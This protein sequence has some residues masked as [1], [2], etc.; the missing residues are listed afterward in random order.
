ML[1][2]SVAVH[3]ADDSRHS[4]RL[5]LAVTLSQRFD[6][7]LNV[8]YATEG[9][10][11]P[12]GTIGRSASMQYMDAGRDDTHARI[13][14]ARQ[15]CERHCA[16]L[17]SWEWHQAH[18]PVDKIVARFA[19]LADLV[20]AEQAPRI[21]LEDGLIQHMS[22]F[23]VI[24]AGC[25]M[26]LVPDGWAAGE[27]G[28]RVLVAWKNEPQ[29]IAAIRGSLDFLSAATEVHVLAAADDRDVDPPG[30]DIV[31]YLAH[32]GVSA[33]VCGIS[34]RGGQD[35]LS[36]AEALNC[37]L[38]VMGAYAHSRWRELVLGGATDH[39]MR[40]ATIPVLMRH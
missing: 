21:H 19:H 32:H 8:V 38:I 7:H 31:R 26:L 29:A 17:R 37:D 36:T 34:R 23:L 11:R 33:E 28:T 18:G 22:D 2:K 39:V 10:G 40:H 1:I 12:A 15:E 25:P 6:A 35:I 16:G 30:S 9:V 24:A 14:T 20:V 4:V 3:L 27:V 5:R 13:D